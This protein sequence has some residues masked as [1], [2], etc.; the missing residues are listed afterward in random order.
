VAT[1]EKFNERVLDIRTPP[2]GR[3][4]VVEGYQQV[5]GKRLHSIG[6]FDAVTAKELW[7]FQISGGFD[8]SMCLDR[9]GQFVAFPTNAGTR[10]V[11]V[12]LDTGR[13]VEL[14]NARPS[15]L[16]PQATHWFALTAVGGMALFS[17]GGTNALL[18][19]G[20]DA[21]HTD[22]PQLDSAWNLM[23]WGHVD[24][25]ASVYDLGAMRRQLNE[26]GAGW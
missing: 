12:E 21:Q 3:L 18:T 1:I 14:L 24:G 8:A 25:T 17:K 5:E 15:T 19:V 26:I 6:A 10:S 7:S 2:D 16:G 11:V 13:V 20:I 23:L 4:F 22:R 9:G